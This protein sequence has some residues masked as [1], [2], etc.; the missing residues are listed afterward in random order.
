M[1]KLL[2]ND[3]IACINRCFGLYALFFLD[4]QAVCELCF[5]K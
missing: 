5:G 2:V 4:K 1:T 3:S